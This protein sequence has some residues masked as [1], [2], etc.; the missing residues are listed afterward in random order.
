LI[1]ETKKVF[2]PQK[3]P[4][5]EHG[6]IHPF[7]ARRDD[8]V[9]GRV[10]AIRNRAHEEFHG[11]PV[12]FFGFFEA[13]DD[14]E[15]A[16]SLVEAA[17]EHLRVGG[18][19]AMRGPVSPSTNEECGLLV[20]GFDTPP[21]VL[22]PHNPPYYESLLTGAGLAKIKD[23]YAFVAHSRDGQVPERLRKGAALVRRRQPDVVVRPL[24]KRR[25]RDEVEIFRKVYNAAWQRNWGFVPMTDAEI[26]HMAEQLKPAVDPGLI[27]IAEVDGTPVGFA[28]GLPDLNQA[29]RHADGKLFPFGLLKI[30]WYSRRIRRARIAVLGLVEGYRKTGIDVILYHDLFEYGLKRGYT[31]GEFSWILEDN[32]SMIRPLELM[33]ASVY[34]TYRLYETPVELG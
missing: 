4:F 19:R 30:L 25:F 1:G 2:D 22:T 12:G 3:N 11:E 6:D 23:L 8:E 20:D 26:D 9:V 7:I 33:G 17:R 16:G 5:F 29:L 34:K 15:V 10:A 27:R 14:P 21:M 28:L 32:I 31:T 18:L 24:N 13:E